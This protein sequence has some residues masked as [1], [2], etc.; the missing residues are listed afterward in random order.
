VP[1]RVISEALPW[2]SRQVRPWTRAVVDQPLCC[3]LE[4]AQADDNYGGRSD[5]G[6]SAN[7][8][9]SDS[10]NPNNDAYWSSRGR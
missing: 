6:N 3:G 5:D 8:H 1:K 7:D 9:R 10:M 2:E 4:F